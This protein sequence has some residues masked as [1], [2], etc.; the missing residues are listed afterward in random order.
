MESL[1]LAVFLATYLGMALGRAPG[2]KLD[3]AGIALFAAV[4]LLATNAVPVEK[5]GQRIDLPTLLLLFG[6]MI[7][8]AQ[9]QGAGFYRYAAG[10]I[11]TAQGSPL[12]LLGLTV[13][14]AG[15]L[16]AL[17]AN[18]IVVFAMAPIL[19]LGT[20]QRGLDPRPFLIALAGA[21]NAG[22]AI[23]VIG[24]PQNILIGQVGGLD[25]WR[26]AA[27]C[28]V[29]G[30]LALLAVF[31]VVWAG[32]RE[33]L[34]NPP[35]A[36]IKSIEPVQAWPTIKGMLAVLLLILAFATPFPRE[37]SALA[38]A[39]LLLASRKMASRDMIG[40]VDWHLLLLIACLFIVTGAFAE[41]DM[42][43]Q[44]VALL[45]AE[46]WF[47]E[48]L[49]VMTPLLLVLSNSIGNVPAVILLLSL[50]GT[51]DA[52]TL[53]GMALIS[54]LSGNLLL[55]GSLANIIVAERAASVGVRLSF[56]DHAKSGIPMTL[57]SLTLAVA[58]LWAMGE[59]GG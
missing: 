40:A 36:S 48:S 47:L 19:A 26:F 30:L 35:A 32:W 8:S 28:A 27:V 33:S 43:A 56:I 3:R 12:L 50:F 22:S 11:A 46:G 57:I 58:W 9:L 44:G 52:G 24:N 29:P 5:L 10:R 37:L 31:L 20:R 21:S 25:F 54:T 55:T 39:A 38:I 23:T 14:V 53:H 15:G 18:D 17:L 42:A 59:M 34:R 41:L 13:G 4:V 2:L 49:S 1:I 7:I 51:P 16:S 45:K 6:L